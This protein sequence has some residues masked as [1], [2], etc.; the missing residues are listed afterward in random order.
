MSPPTIVRDNA[1][2]GSWA[3]PPTEKLR[4]ADG[5]LHLWRMSLTLSEEQR[6]RYRGLLSA[7]EIERAE[8]FLVPRARD[9]FIAARAQMRGILAGYLGETPSTLRFC[10]GELGKPFLGPRADA[11]S[12]QFSLSHSDEIALLA[13]TR[14][15]A[16]GVDVERIRDD[17]EYEGIADQLFTV[18]EREHLESLDGEPRRVAFFR[19]WT[20]KECVLKALATGFSIPPN[21]CRA[22]LKLGL[23][24]VVSGDRSVVRRKWKV[25]SLVPSEGYMAAAAVP[26]QPKEVFLWDCAQKASTT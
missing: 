13:V 15:D 12:L 16:V 18:E 5:D 21:A 11:P 2:G 3:S 7:D 14:S 25:L 26:I 4:L 19:Y 1:I 6:R 9:S 24:T 10:Y 22:D 8:K 23:A 20:Y 17:V